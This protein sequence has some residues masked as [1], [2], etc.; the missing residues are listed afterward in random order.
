MFSGIIEEIGMVTRVSDTA[1]ERV[2]SIRTPPGWR[3]ADGGSVSVEGVCSTVQRQGKRTIQVVYMHETLRRT[4]LGSL[5][6]GSPVNLERSLR[7]N[8]VVGGHLVQGHVDATAR[9]LG[10]RSD[11]TAKIYRFGFPRRHLRYI[12]EKGSVA[13][14][15]IS[16]T[17]VAASASSFTVSLLAYTLGH[18]TLGG[19]GRGARVNLEVDLVAKYVEGLLNR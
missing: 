5:G 6:L 3:I 7:L 10:V 4:T 15:G 8:G 19:K 17:V 1:C 12:V 16:L 13:I 2:M 18:T 11:G 14:D 9:I